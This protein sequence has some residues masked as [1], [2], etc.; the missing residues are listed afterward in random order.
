MLVVMTYIRD[1]GFHLKSVRKPQLSIVI[2][3][4]LVLYS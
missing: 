4:E 1:G 3:Y 2:L